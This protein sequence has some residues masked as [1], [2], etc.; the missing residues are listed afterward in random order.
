MLVIPLI[1]QVV[2]T[3]LVV[4]YL[5]YRSGQAAVEDLV[6]QAMGEANRR[7]VQ[8]LDDYVRASETLI[9]GQRLTIRLGG[10]DWQ[11]AAFIESYFVEQLRINPQVSELMIATEAKDFLAIGRPP[12]T[13][14]AI[15]ERNPRT[16]ALENYA[17]DQ[18]GNRLYLQGVVENYDPHVTPSGDPWYVAARG[19]EAGLWRIVA[20]GGRGQGKPSLVMTYVLPFTDA[21]GNAQGVL[22]AS[23]YLDHIGEF[24]SSL[25]SS[26]AGRV[27]ILDDLGHLIATSTG[28][29]P[30]RQEV[31]AADAADAVDVETLVPEQWRLAAQESQ[32]P[33]T[34]AAALWSLETQGVLSLKAQRVRLLDQAYFVQVIPFEVNPGLAWRVVVLVPEADLT[35]RINANLRLMLWASGLVLFGAVGAGYWAARRLT[36]SLLRLTQTAQSME[37]GALDLPLPDSRIAEVSKVSQALH[38]MHQQVQQ[39]LTTLQDSEQK[40]ATLLDSLPMGVGVLDGEGKMLLLNRMGHSIFQWGMVDNPLD[41]SDAYNIYLAE[42]DQT[43]PPDRRPI[44]RALRGETVY[45]DDLEVEIQ[46]RRIPLEI[47]TAPVLN[48]SGEIIYV[49]NA[50]QDISDR[51][52][53]EADRVAAQTLAH[54]LRLLEQV[55]DVILAGYW[56]WNIPVHQEY[57]SPGLKRMFGYEDHELP[58]TPEAWQ[59]LIVPEDLPGVLACFERHV[60][61]HGEEPFYNEVRYRHKDG[62]TVWVMCSGQVI[63][64]DDRGQPLRMVG[65][66]IDISDRKHLELELQES[67]ATLQDILENAPGAIVTL[68]QLADRFWVVTYRSSGCEQVFGY[69]VKELKDTPG[70]WL[71]R[72][73]E[74]DRHYAITNDTSLDSLPY[75]RT[76]EYRFRHKDGEI[77]WISAVQSIRWDDTLQCAI[78]TLIESDITQSKRAELALQDSEARYRTLLE[79]SP[80]GIFR[81]DVTG[82]CIYAN[83]KLQDMTGRPLEDILGDG[84]N[85]NLHPEDQA[86]MT[87]A[88]ATFVEQSNLGYEAIYQHEYRYFAADG[89]ERWAFVQAVPEHSASGILIGF[90][91]STVD[92][93][94]RKHA[95]KLLQDSEARYLSILQD[96]TE[97][98][99]RYRP[100]GTILFVNNAFCRYFGL[101]KKDVV[102][103]Q[104]PSSV[105]SDDRSIVDGCVASLSPEHP[106]GMVEH[107]VV[108]ERGVRW[109]Q[110]TNRAIYDEQGRLIEL[111][112]VGRDIHDRK[113][114]EER[115]RASEAAL[116]EAQ[117]VAHIGNWMFDPVN[118]TI[119]WSRELY[120]MF[121]LD[122]SQPAPAYADHLQKIHPDDRPTLLQYVERAIAH[123]TPYTFDYRAIQPDGSLRYHEGR[124]KVEQDAQGQVIRLFGTALD[125]TKRKFMEEALQASESR[126]RAIFEQAAVGIN[127]ADR[128]GRLVEANQHFCTM[129]G[130][131]RDELLTLTV[132]DITHPDDTLFHDRPVPR[133]F[134]EGID[135]FTLEKRYRHKNGEW[136][137][138]EVTISAVRDAHGQAYCD[139]AIV[140]DIR[141]RQRLERE[142]KA[143]QA[144]LSSILNS[145]EASI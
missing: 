69:S 123:G 103:R 70:L 132:Q 75:H 65:C 47:K 84:W 6:D 99:K 74:E 29:L 32:D 91:G 109:M 9:Q 94:D 43:Y 39:S 80:V 36:R 54:E 8:T 113:L 1:V 44:V 21:V 83:P 133:I 144:Q 104:Y 107:R 57:L 92:I 81:N 124:G 68:R 62:S 59:N 108:T 67:K 61:S 2:G 111:Q 140:I 138:A 26:E 125:I 105:Y 41:S 40:F 22:G 96:Q 25:P 82:Q 3:V 63:E 33:L 126:F 135:A 141:D 145:A 4:D 23:L 35:G 12:A 93:T 42:T 37:A 71:S 13:P 76:I 87:V 115:V 19:Q 98:I 136:I 27:F 48:E 5:C 31:L 38:H 58:N 137:S 78:A 134:E 7:V 88:W 127:Q 46:G 118:Q 72:V 131:S 18:Q 112:A 121:G 50:F 66:H 51:R 45:V 10:M 77:R 122:P 95:E 64:W 128:T 20:S 60:Q 34:Q 28:E 30:F 142:L 101:T 129:L 116:L 139:L 97:L 17:A 86:S 85:R 119:T 11:N 110:W 100:D 56:D 24:L 49:I 143:S 73:V 89:S 15:W 52:Q 114:A 55:L 79:T 102:G 53:A 106:A 16:G 117:Q 120:R 130:Y 14:F 90:V